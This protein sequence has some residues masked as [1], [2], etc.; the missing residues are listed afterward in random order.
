MFDIGGVESHQLGVLA[1][2]AAH[3]SQTHLRTREIQL[4]SINPCSLGHLGQFNP[5][6]LGRTH[7]GGND[8]LVGVVLLEPA[9]D[10]KIHFDGILA[11]LLH[12]AQGGEITLV[13]LT[14][15]D[16]K[17]RRHLVDVIQADGLVEDACPAGIKGTGHHLVVG[18]DR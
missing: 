6:L 16:I 9:Q 18:A 13:T 14:V 8:N 2:I 17:A 15:Q 4:H 12:V 7:D 11:Q 10:V 3:A 1:Y 5:L